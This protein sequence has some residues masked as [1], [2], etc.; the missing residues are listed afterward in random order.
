MSSRAKRC[1]LAVFM[2]L[3]RILRVLLMNSLE[4]HCE[5]GE[6]ISMNSMDCRFGLAASSQ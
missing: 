4:G 2:K 6:A 5:R 1:D 3:P